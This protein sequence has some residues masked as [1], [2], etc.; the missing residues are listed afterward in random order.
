MRIRVQ[1]NI[2]MSESLQV[3]SDALQQSTGKNFTDLVEDAFKLYAKQVLSAEEQ[4][5]IANKLYE[6]T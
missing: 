4:A 5:V 6:L 3:L 1:K 2:R